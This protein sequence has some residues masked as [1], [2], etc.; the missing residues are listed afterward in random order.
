[1]E[2]T[3]QP[4]AGSP[5]APTSSHPGP[6]SAPM[7]PSPAYP[8]RGTSSA[9]AP[10][11]ASATKPPSSTTSPGHP[12]ALP[13][14]STGPVR[15][16]LTGAADGSLRAWRTHPSA[17]GAPLFAVH[18]HAGAIRRLLLPRGQG[19]GLGYE[20]G[21]SCPAAFRHCVVSAADDGSLALVCLARGAVLRTCRVP[22]GCMGLPEEVAWCA[23]R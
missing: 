9:P 20:G 1:M 10:P 17:F 15:L 12:F 11:H 23:R 4:P 3:F 8:L 7:P 5:L 22:P 19:L 18:P 14:P 13:Q 6:S 2:V 16:L 21:G